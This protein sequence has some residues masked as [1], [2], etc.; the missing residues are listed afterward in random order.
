MI[1]DPWLKTPAIVAHAAVSRTIVLRALASGALPGHR[2][3]GQTSPWRVRTS[4]VDE[5][6]KA[7][8][9]VDP[10]TVTT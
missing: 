1:H 8:C 5:W 6:I 7:G 9:P 3:E 4:A 10:V 2:G